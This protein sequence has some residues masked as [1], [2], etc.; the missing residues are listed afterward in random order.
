MKTLEY[1]QTD[2][3]LQ[4]LLNR[5]I[6]ADVLK[7]YILNVICKTCN[8]PVKMS[9]P[10]NQHW[11]F[12]R[13]DALSVAQLTVSEHWKGKVLHTVNFLTQFHIEICVTGCDGVGSAGSLSHFIY[14]FIH[15]YVWFLCEK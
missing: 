5:P 4:T 6:S 1:Q 12:Y 3:V 14:M 8:A 11:A 10:T 7:T 9:P 13:P 2:L 15:L